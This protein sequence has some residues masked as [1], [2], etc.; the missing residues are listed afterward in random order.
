MGQLPAHQGREG[1][2]AVQQPPGGIGP[3]G[4]IVQQGPE[5]LPAD[6]Q[7]VRLLLGRGETVE[8]A[9]EPLPL[10]AHLHVHPAQTVDD[11]VLAVQKDQVGVAAH[12]LQHQ[13]PPS[14]LP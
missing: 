4:G 7:R 5:V 8:E 13:P 6:G 9:G 1:G 14:L 11:P 12:A 2:E 10:L 3:I